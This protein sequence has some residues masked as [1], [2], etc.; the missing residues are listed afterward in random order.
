M[1]DGQRVPLTVQPEASGRA[2]LGSFDVPDVARI[3]AMPA[4]PAP[5]APPA[6]PAPREPGSAHARLLP[7]PRRPAASSSSTS[8]SVSGNGRLGLTVQDLQPQL[9]EY[10]GVR[11]G[12]LVTSVSSG[13]TAEKAGVKA[14]D[15]ITT[16]N[17]AAVA[18]ASDLRQRALRLEDGAEL[19][20]GVVRDKKTMTLKGKVEGVSERRRTRS[21]NAA[22]G[23]GGFDAGVGRPAGWRPDQRRELR[24]EDRGGGE[25][26]VQLLGVAAH[27]RGHDPDAAA[28]RHQRRGNRAIAAAVAVDG[29]QRRGPERRRGRVLG[30]ARDRAEA[31]DQVLRVSLGENRI[32]LAPVRVGNPQDDPGCVEQRRGALEE[33]RQRHR[34]VD[35]GEIRAQ[36]GHRR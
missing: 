12:V 2:A 32:E 15:V 26:R 9:A 29:L 23:V 27:F 10:F 34:V 4:P 5:P 24:R 33:R 28:T 11:E 1:R 14:G 30:V 20:L 21:V 7:R 22:S 3:W 19:T 35:P 31:V 18:S 25:I 6:A 8:C 16:L 36:R 17:G 13:S